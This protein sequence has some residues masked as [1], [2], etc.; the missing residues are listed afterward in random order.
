MN[1]ISQIS[2]TTDS[3]TILPER[4]WHEQLTI[5]PTQITLKRHGR[6][7]N[8]TINAGTWEFAADTPQVRELFAQLATINWATIKRVEPADPPDGG[9]AE[10]Y[11]IVYANNQSYTLTYDPGVT[12]T[13]DQL[14][15]KPI[16][17]FIRRLTLPAAAVNRY[18][19]K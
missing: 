2:Y 8:S 3:G 17:A 11:T 4:Q 18:G 5:T 9:G 7:E 1:H 15:V 14:I 10:S 13:H 16:Q 19:A 6:A 12:Y